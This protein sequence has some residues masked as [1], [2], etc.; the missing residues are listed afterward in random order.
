MRYRFKLKCRFCRSSRRVKCLIYLKSSSFFFLYIFSKF[1]DD[2]IPLIS[3]KESDSIVLT[4]SLKNNDIYSEP[5]YAT[6]IEIDFDD[7][8]DF[9]RKIDQVTIYLFIFVAIEINL[10][11]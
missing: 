10:V 4:I 2:N 8:L 6:Q 5:A 1:R 3:F 11:E 9:I 7:R